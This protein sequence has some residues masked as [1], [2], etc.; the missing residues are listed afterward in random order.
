MPVL[1]D[2]LHSVGRLP[3]KAAVRSPGNIVVKG[4]RENRSIFGG[5]RAQGSA[6]FQGCTEAYM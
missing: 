3:A 2:A 6:F 1:E 4:V 5:D